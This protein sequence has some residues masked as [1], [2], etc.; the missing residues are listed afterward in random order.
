MLKF[1]FTKVMFL[2]AVSILLVGSANATDYWCG[3]SLYNPTMTE[4]TF[5]AKAKGNPL[6]KDFYA[7]AVKAYRSGACAE[8]NRK[9]ENIYGAKCEIIFNKKTNKVLARK[10]TDPDGSINYAALDKLRQMYK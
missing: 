6:C 5:C 8:I 9:Y 10:C 4:N 1:R 2:C 7:D 3:M